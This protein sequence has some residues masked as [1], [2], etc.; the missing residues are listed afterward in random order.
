[1][2]SLYF[3]SLQNP[4]CNFLARVFELL[5]ALILLIRSAGQEAVQTESRVIFRRGDTLQARHVSAETRYHFFLLKIN[6]LYRRILFVV[7]SDCNSCCFSSL[8]IPVSSCLAQD[9]KWYVTLSHIKAQAEP[10]AEC[11]CINT[12]GNQNVPGMVVLPSNGRTYG[13]CYLITFTVGLLC[14]HTH[15]HTHTHTLSLS[16][17]LSL[18]LLLHGSCH[19]WKHRRK[20]SVGIFRSSA[21]AFDLLPSTVA[22]RVPLR[23]IFRAGNSQNSLGARSE[24]TVVGWWHNRRC[25]ARCVIVMQKPLSLPATCHTVSSAELAR[26]NEQ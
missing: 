5:E 15:T 21:V 25:V 24:S 2:Y 4:A 8:H 18:S 17:S 13:N 20:A 11:W 16:L 10:L 19:C 3:W 12:I 26:R 6:M 22:K 23:P 14:K 1:M 9:V 7:L